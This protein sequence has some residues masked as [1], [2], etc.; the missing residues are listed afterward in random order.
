MLTITINGRA[1]ALFCFDAGGC[2]LGELGWHIR[3]L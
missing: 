3:E 2:S 1:A